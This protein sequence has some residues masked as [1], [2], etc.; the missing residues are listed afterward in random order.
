MVKIIFKK[1]DFYENQTFIYNHSSNF[2][3]S[4][5]QVDVQLTWA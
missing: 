4:V 3:C 5:F 1:L 2:R